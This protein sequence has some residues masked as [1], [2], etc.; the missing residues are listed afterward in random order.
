MSRDSQAGNADDATRV[1]VTRLNRAGGTYH[2]FELGNGLVIDGDYDM[3]KYLRHFRLPP[4]LDGMS[5]LDVGTAA[6]YLAL[7]CARRGANVTAIDL[8]ESSEAL[9]VACEAFGVTVRYLRKSV[10]ELDDSFGTFDIVLCGSMLLH[11][12][13]PL[14]AI[15]RIRAVCRGTAIVSTTCPSDSADNDRPLCEFLGIHATDGD[16]WHYWTISAA[17]LRRMLLAAGFS[18][19]EHEA[20]FILQSEPGR[21]QYVSPHVVISAVV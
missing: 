14:D 6:G 5:V 19:I 11:L 7:E 9:S 21:T 15:R 18:R 3:T 12:A 17:A 10:F 8:W 1:R 2:K 20:H 13:S 16:Y 4:R